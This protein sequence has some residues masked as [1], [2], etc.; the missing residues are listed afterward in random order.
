MITILGSI[1]LDLIA[2]S[3]RLPE[4]GETLT[5]TGFANASG[6]KGA[7]QA[8][9]VLRA[10]ADMR[11]AGAV[12]ADDF[13][14]S[15]IAELREAG[16]D[17]SLVQTRGTTTGVAVILVGGDGENVIVVVP[18][19]NGL[20]DEAMAEQVV[21]GLSAGDY[22]LLQQEIPVQTIARALDLAAKSGVNTVLNIAPVSSESAALAQK[23]TYVIANE[24]EFAELAGGTVD[25]DNL[26]GAMTGLAKT[27][28]QTLI[29]T[30]GG[31][32]A[33]AAQPDGTFLSVAAPAIMPVDTVGAG[34]TF[35]GY[36]AAGLDAGLDLETAMRRAVIAGSLACLKPGAQPAI[37]T[38]AEVTG[39]TA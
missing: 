2:N 35:C 10:G 6:G 23:A 30:L 17:L 22:L 11:L 16:A 5:G 12:G 38:L 14:A 27:T 9:A 19:A 3:P 28:G 8:M 4:P 39:F 26:A 32:G 34:D 21:S 37:P 13:A 31:K 7:N 33:C 18:G 15:A 25:P 29:V 36:F 20:V 24:S 1:N